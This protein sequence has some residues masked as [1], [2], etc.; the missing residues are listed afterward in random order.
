MPPGAMNLSERKLAEEA[1]QS[2]EARFRS[3]VDSM[4]EGLG[5]AQALPSLPPGSQPL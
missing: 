5:S 4:G 3:V 1:L 2:S